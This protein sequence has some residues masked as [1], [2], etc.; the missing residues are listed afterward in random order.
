MYGI[1][2]RCARQVLDISHSAG[3]KKETDLFSMAALASSAAEA[4]SSSPTVTPQ[5]PML[6]L[7]DEEEPKSDANAAARSKNTSS[8]YEFKS[9]SIPQHRLRHDSKKRNKKFTT[10][11]IRVEVSRLFVCH[12]GLPV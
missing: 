12:R 6:S 5:D 3:Q 7:D 9:V 8:L 10:Y 2:P 4:I 1:T 11:C